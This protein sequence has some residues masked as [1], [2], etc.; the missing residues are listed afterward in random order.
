LRNENDSLSQPTGEES[1]SFEQQQGQK[2]ILSQT[3]QME[4][5]VV[6]ISAVPGCCYF[7]WP[8]GIYLTAGAIFVQ[9]TLI[10]SVGSVVKW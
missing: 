9:R 5:M 4:F 1:T 10:A 7:S 3:G 2:F 8:E 6:F